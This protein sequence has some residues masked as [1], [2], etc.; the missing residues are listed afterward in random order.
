MEN[1]TFVNTKNINPII[2]CL[3]NKEFY[4]YMV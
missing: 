4:Y 2:L 3:Q 1:K